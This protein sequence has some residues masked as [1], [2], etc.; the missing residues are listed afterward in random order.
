MVDGQ[1]PR[2]GSSR[3]C[4]RL[5]SA[6][7]GRPQGARTAR[8][9][10]QRTRG[11]TRSQEGLS[12]P[13]RGMAG[14]APA[15]PERRRTR[16]TATARCRRPA[17]ISCSTDGVHSASSPNRRLMAASSRR[18][19]GERRPRCV[20][21]LSPDNR[22]PMSVA[23]RC[24]GVGAI[25]QPPLRTRRLPRDDPEIGSGR[26]RSLHLSPAFDAGAQPR[27]RGGRRPLIS[28][29]QRLS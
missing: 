22:T 28:H 3:R 14:G 26:F 11:S 7:P 24:S 6:W 17:S 29:E 19:T 18:P 12:R 15:R 25:D 8:Q 1:P 2:A 20:K 21:P 10:L 9:E 5:A 27:S 16:T 4:S 23:A 13:Y